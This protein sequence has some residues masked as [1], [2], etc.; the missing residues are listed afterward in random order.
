MMADLPVSRLSADAPPFF[1]TGVDYF[2]PISVKQGRSVVKRYGCLFYCM[3]IRAVHLELAYSMSTDSFIF[4]L[5]KFISRRGNVAHIYSDNGSNFI[6]AE[7]VL[8]ESIQHW[9]HDQIV[10]YLHQKDINWH[11]NPPRASHS[12]GAWERLVKSVKKVL[13]SLAP[14]TTVFTDEGLS[15]LFVEVEAIVNSLPLFPVSFV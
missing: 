7:K 11:F 9:N 6:G 2:G 5:R 10:P 14:K 1:H 13:T 3:T 12:G 8:R 15:T 4:A